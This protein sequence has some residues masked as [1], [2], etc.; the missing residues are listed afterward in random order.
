MIQLNLQN[1]L[2]EQSPCQTNQSVVLKSTMV[3]TKFLKDHVENY[4]FGMKECN[5][6]VNEIDT[7]EIM[8]TS[9]AILILF[10]KK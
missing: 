7:G 2:N 4:G 5:S 8:K 9:L 6:D 1:Y 10:D 3:S